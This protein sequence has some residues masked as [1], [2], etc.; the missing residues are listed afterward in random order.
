MQ[1]RRAEL[2]DAA[3]QV[4]RR[5]GA[6][7]LT[8]RAVA[9]EAGVPHGSVHYAFSSK[10]AMQQAVVAADTEH[11]VNYFAQA[12]ASGGSPEEVLSAAV[13]AYT[14][15]VKADPQ[16]ELAL[17]EVTLMAARDPGLHEIL[18]ESHVGYQSSVERLLIDLAER[19]GG[20]WD[21][22]VS[23]IAQQ[24]LGMVFG[25]A[26]SWLVIR[27]DSMLDTVLQDAARATAAR[28]RTAPQS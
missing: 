23:V 12:G 6:W 22:P 2:A 24:L 3:L 21:A 14:D 25:V 11:A 4:M 5:D 1:Q 28:L 19:S 18:E 10:E 26:M 9:K 16:T 27:D 7:T 15:G 8:T 20:E 17:Q 13:K